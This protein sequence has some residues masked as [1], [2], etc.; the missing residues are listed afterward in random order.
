MLKTVRDNALAE[1]PDTRPTRES[2]DRGRISVG[3]AVA[4]ILLLVA[5]LV[6]VN[7]PTEGLGLSVS[8]TKTGLWFVSPLLQASLSGLNLWL[9]LSLALWVVNLYYGRW[10]RATRWADFGLSVLGV[11]VLGQLFQDVLPGLSGVHTLIQPGQPPTTLAQ[12]LKNVG[13][14]WMLAVSVALT[15]AL[16]HTFVESVRK[17]TALIRPKRG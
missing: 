1:A 15:I 11:L 2:D 4:R 16:V 10:Y 6:V 14:W 12:I 9:T 7:M 3:S 8:R 13:T 17:L 5:L